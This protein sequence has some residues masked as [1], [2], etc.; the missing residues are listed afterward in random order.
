MKVRV[1]ALSLIVVVFGVSVALASPQHAANPPIILTPGSSQPIS[2]AYGLT[3]TLNEPTCPAATP[4]VTPQ[5]QIFT[6]LNVPSEGADG[7]V[8]C[9]NGT[10]AYLSTGT[11]QGYQGVIAHCQPGT[12]VATPTP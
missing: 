9:N 2:C 12:P 7:I 3:G 8:T 4:T 5:T 11:R 10:V 1:I 6:L